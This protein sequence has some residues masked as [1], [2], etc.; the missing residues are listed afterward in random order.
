MKTAIA[1]LELT[2]II[3]HLSVS[4]KAD[5]PGVSPVTRMSCVLLLWVI[6]G[7]APIQETTNTDE[8]WELFDMDANGVIDQEPQDDH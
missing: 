2:T 8:L 6:H 4:D 1:F 7:S 3:R 5:K